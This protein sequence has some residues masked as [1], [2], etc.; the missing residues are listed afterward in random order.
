[1]CGSI[2]ECAGLVCVSYPV[3]NELVMVTVSVLL[4]SR[5]QVLGVV[6]HVV[7]RDVVLSKARVF[8]SR[9]HSSNRMICLDCIQQM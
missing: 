8:S 5:G 3:D 4:L 6:M 7:Q 1:M 2:E 9:K